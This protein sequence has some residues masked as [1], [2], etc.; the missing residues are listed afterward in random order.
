M[1]AVPPPQNQMAAL[2]EEARRSRTFLLVSGILAIITG[3]V[4][5]VVPAIFSVATAILVGILLLILAGLLIGFAFAADGGWQV[6]LR[7]GLAILAAIAGVYL[8]AAPLKGTFTL[9]VILAAWFFATGIMRLFTA[10]QMRGEQGA[11]LVGFNGAVTLILGL[12]IAVSLPSSADWAIG[13]LVGID[14]LFYGVTA[15]TLA[16]AA[17]RATRA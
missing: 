11:G 1:A 10:Y 6:A 8:L 13:L 12:L 3:F 5:I 9:T 4:A 2:A 16:G 17:K 15:I 7:L 14:F